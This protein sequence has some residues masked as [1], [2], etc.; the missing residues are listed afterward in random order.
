M[1]TIII[2]ILII[3]TITI[4]ISIFIIIIIR[5][6]DHLSDLTGKV[7]ILEHHLEHKFVALQEKISDMIAV[8]QAKEGTIEE[9]IGKL[10]VVMQTVSM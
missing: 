9:E 4:I 10:E 7:D 6:I 1:T 8:V 5:F 3:T 2:V